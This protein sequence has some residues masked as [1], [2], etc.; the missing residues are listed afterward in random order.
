MQ[1]R[2]SL[3]P[4]PSRLTARL[5]LR[6]AEGPFFS[7]LPEAVGD[8]DS[9][10][11]TNPAKTH[12]AIAAD[13]GTAARTRCTRPPADQLF[14]FLVGQQELLARKSAL[15]IAG[16][17]QIVARLMVEELA[18]DGIR[19]AEDVATCLNGYDQT[20][21]PE[22]TQWS[23]AR[24]YLPQAFDAGCRPVGDASALCA[25]LARL[26]TLRRFSSGR[27]GG[28]VG[29]WQALGLPAGA[30]HANMATGGRTKNGT[31]SLA[32]RAPLR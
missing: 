3:K 29:H 14:T 30:A 26:A 23:F 28:T 19:N 21:Y 12:A 25:R 22:G 15:P 20:A 10:A 9:N 2:R 8:H 13:P 7:N 1:R 6:H 32:S 31:A 16:K 11:G 17:T 24:F 4:F 27:N 18:F 5:T